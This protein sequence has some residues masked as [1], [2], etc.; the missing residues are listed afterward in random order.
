MR[1]EQPNILII[2]ADQ[3][4]APAL[5]CYGNPVTKTPHLDALVEDGV[6][7]DNAYCNNPLCAP[8]RFSMMAGQHSSAIGA[9]DNGAEFPADIPTFAHYL[10]AG[11]YR[12]TLCGKM[13]FVGA[14]QLHGFEER[15]TT[16]VYPADHG[17]A[18]DWQRP[19]HR[20]DWWYHN[21]DSV[22]E[23]GP[24]ER[25]NQID[26]DD[27]VGF[28]A[29]RHIYDLARDSDERPFCLTVSFTDPHDPYAC[30]KEFWDLYED[31]EINLPHV[32]HIPYEQC[33]P[34]SQRL[35]HAYKMGQGEIAPEDIRN[36]RRAY[37]GQISYVDAKIGRIMKALEDCGLRENT[38]VVFTA[39]HGDMLGER[40]LWYKMS[41]HE[42]SA[43]VPF[44]VS[45]PQ[46]FQPGRVTTPVSLVDL[47]PTLLDLSGDPHLEAPADRLDGQSLVPL[48]Q[49]EVASLDRPVISEYLGEGAVAPM[50]MVRWG[51]YKYIACP[52]DP[53]LLFDLQE[54]PDELAN[55]AG[56][57]EMQDIE[58]QLDQVVRKHQDLNQLHE[59]VVASQQRRRLVFVAHM[60]GTHTPWDFQ[61]VFDAT[62]RYM[63]NHLDLNDVEGR[64]RI[65]S[66]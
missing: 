61:P 6:V 55:L 29:Q 20:F 48:L 62:N 26:F 52:A 63:R 15:L 7:F 11:G 46:R 36:A 25:T 58:V 44:I 65:E 28:R 64:A 66:T 39:D 2:Q 19:E 56:R 10:R 12:T 18:P 59:A 51:R 24:C 22:Y 37:Y 5:S 1:G 50:V 13:H 21:M 57:P 49:G 9:Y 17:W 14:D 38:I 54:D 3:L 27:E 34:H 4:A 45:A 32:E 35:R 33:D 47:L 43:R 30:P 8:S 23:A 41:F 31:E 60:T 40:G 16:D 53:P 42:W